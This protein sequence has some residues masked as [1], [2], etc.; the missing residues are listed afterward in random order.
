M[1]KKAGAWLNR[2][3]LTSPL[4]IPLLASPQKVAMLAGHMKRLLWILLIC[5][6]CIRAHE[7]V[8]IASFRTDVTPPLGSALCNGGVKPASEIIQP[9]TAI[10]LVLVVPKQDPIVLCAV[11]WTG[12]GNDSNKAWR[13]ALAKAAGTTTDRVAIHTLHQH[14]APGCDFTAVRLLADYGLDEL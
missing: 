7:P 13:A 2:L 10:G 9:L 6:L 12:I 3:P 11:D 1:N 14:D 4:P 8:R 5:P